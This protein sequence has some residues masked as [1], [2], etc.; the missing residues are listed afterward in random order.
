TRATCG[1]LRRNSKEV[2]HGKRPRLRDGSRFEANCRQPNARPHDV[3][4][5]L[6]RLLEGVRQRPPPVRAYSLTVRQQGNVITHFGPARH[7][8]E[9]GGEAFQEASI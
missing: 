7:P 6:A 9:R 8:P 4:L 5:L 2:T 3:L 1:T